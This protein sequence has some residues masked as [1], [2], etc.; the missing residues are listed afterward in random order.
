MQAYTHKE[1]KPRFKPFTLCIDIESEDELNHI[2]SR[3]NTSQYNLTGS[4]CE[5]REVKPL[6]TASIR[7]LL[8][9][10]FTS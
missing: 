5:Y 6:N 8:R 3:F 9:E 4:G 1:N 2:Y 7:D 10:H